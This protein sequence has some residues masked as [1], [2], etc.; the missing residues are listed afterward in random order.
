MKNLKKIISV[1]LLSVSVLSLTPVTAY[2][3]GKDAITTDSINFRDSGSIYS[4]VLAVVPMGKTVEVLETTEKWALV[5]YNNKTGWVSLNYIFYTEDYKAMK[6]ITNIAPSKLR[7]SASSTST[8]LTTFK[9]R[10][11]GN[12]GFPG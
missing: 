3:K 1:L 7:K 5:K 12:F 4:N 9:G 8:V 2:A 6:G 10:I 11:I